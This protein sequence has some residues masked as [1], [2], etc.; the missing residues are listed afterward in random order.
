MKRWVLLLL[1]MPLFSFSQKDS[2]RF[3][4]RFNL[5]INSG[6]VLVNYL[7]K[8]IVKYEVFYAQKRGINIPIDINLNYRNKFF[9]FGVGSN[10]WLYYDVKSK[11]GV[12]F[13]MK[14]KNEKY[15]FGPFYSFQWVLNEDYLNGVEGSHIFGLDLYVKKFHLGFGYAKYILREGYVNKKDVHGPL[16]NIGYSLNLDS[17]R[18]KKK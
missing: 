5:E 1:F 12:N 9:S 2:T 8:T 17:F 6:A 18:K 10:V 13:L 14:N 4:D 16:L 11:I 7:Q 15:Y 3:Q